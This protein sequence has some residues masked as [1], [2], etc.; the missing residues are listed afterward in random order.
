VIPTARIAND[1]RRTGALNTLVNIYGFIDDHVFLTKSG[2]LGVVLALDGVDDDCLD[3]EQR[4]AVTRRFEIA[5]RVLDESMRL[6]QYLLKQNHSVKAQTR[7]ADPLVDSLLTRRDEFLQSK[8]SCLYTLTLYNVIVAE[9]RVS[10]HSWSGRLHNALTAPFTTIRNRL[11]PRRSLMLFDEEIE[12]LRQH[13]AL[14]VEA[15]VAQLEDTVRPRVLSKAEAFAFFRQ[16]LNYDQDRSSS[17]RL[18]RDTF[19]DYDAADSAL[20]C[21]RSHLRLDDYYVRVLTLKEPP[22]Q[23]FPHILRALHD[24]PSSL[25]LMNDWQREGQGAIRRE[26]HAKRRHFHNSK[27]SLV[28][29]LGEAPTTHGELLVD[30]SATALVKDLG[31]CLTELTTQG[32]YFGQ[33]TMTIV[34]YDTDPAALDRSVASCVKAAAAHDAQLTG[35]RANLLNAWLAVLPGNTAYNFRSMH[36]L[37]TNYADLSFLSC[38]DEGESTNSH[39]RSESLAVLETSQ[40]T[41][42]NLNLHVNDVAHTLILG[43]TGSG[44]SFFLNF[45]IAHLQRYSP[46]TTIFDLGGSYQS[47]TQYFKGSY[48]RLGLDRREVTINPFSLPQTS[49]NLQFLFGFVKVLIESGGQYS[50]SMV[51]DRDLYEQLETLYALD[52]DQR[53]LFTLANILRRPLAQQLQRWV[54]GGPYASLFDHVEDTLTLSRF[55]YIDFEGLD[56]YPQLL[57]PLLF[58]V[59]HRADAATNDPA[60]ADTLKVFVLDEAWRFLRDPTIRQYVTEALKTWRKK[61]ACMLLATQ[62]SEDL[63]TSEILRVAIESCPT[64]CFLANPNI[65]RAVYRELF[66]LNETEA[67]RIATLVPRQQL[68]LKQP[69]VSKVLALSVDPESALLFSPAPTRPP[70]KSQEISND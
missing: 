48:L 56:V 46:R 25:I 30:D 8:R 7:V 53:R 54:Q 1:F 5:L 29:Y 37:N 42:Y 34:L 2:D 67:E 51:D 62:S 43:A 3:N 28:S 57:E 41:P 14:K 19:V 18:A 6:S 55:Q 22:T 52:R 21:H 20:E 50:M 70:N 65:D 47:L 31:A 58:Y 68:L 36:L 24:I 33:Y 10:N 35:E 9:S 45:L 26:I 40:A 63:V 38:Q 61:Q 64:K 39:L 4:E 66:H 23:T 32:R 13:L 12:R 15:F 59:L 44:K 27:V 17:I 49:A 16:L 69:G 60:L 11:S